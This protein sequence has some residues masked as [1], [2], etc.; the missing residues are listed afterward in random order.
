MVGLAGREAPLRPSRGASFCY[1]RVD[2]FA[3]APR[4]DPVTLAGDLS[5]AD[6]NHTMNSGVRPGIVVVAVVAGVFWNGTTE[7]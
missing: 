5:A 7:P 3:R 1:S 4:S 2:A 6:R